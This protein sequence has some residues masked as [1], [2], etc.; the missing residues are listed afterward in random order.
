MVADSLQVVTGVYYPALDHADGVFGMSVEHLNQAL[1]YVSLSGIVGIASASWSYSSSR[2]SPL[3]SD[4][5][6]AKS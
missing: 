5:F 3:R 4:T 6:T 1:V 2:P